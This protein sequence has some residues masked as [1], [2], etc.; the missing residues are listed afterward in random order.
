MGVVISLLDIWGRVGVDLWTYTFWNVFFLPQRQVHSI[1][2]AKILLIEVYGFQTTDRTG[3]GF[4]DRNSNK[5]KCCKFKVLQL[6]LFRSP[7][8]LQP[9]ILNFSDHHLLRW[10]YRSTQKMS[11]LIY[12]WV[13]RVRLN[14]LI[15]K[16]FLFSQNKETF[17]KDNLWKYRFS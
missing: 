7:E 14:P 8:S 9:C 6:L 3:R 16:A 11:A 10:T 4:W 5:V 12:R 13:K 1:R 17:M 15:G 2:W